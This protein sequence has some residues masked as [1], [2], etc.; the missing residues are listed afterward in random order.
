M[1]TCGQL[2]N[3]LHTKHVKED[4]LGVCWYDRYTLYS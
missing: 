4:D 2:G 1:M 3:K